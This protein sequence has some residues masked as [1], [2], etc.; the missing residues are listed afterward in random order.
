M[1]NPSLGSG[2]PDMADKVCLSRPL[3]GPGPKPG[4]IASR[5]RTPLDLK[6]CLCAIKKNIAGNAATVFFYSDELLLGPF[7]QKKPVAP[8]DVLILFGRDA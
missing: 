8:A 4:R 5:E 1:H 3:I 6:E 2:V 7:S